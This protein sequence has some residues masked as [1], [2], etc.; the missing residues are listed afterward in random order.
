METYCA[1]VSQSTS[2]RN[3]SPISNLP[4]E[5]L[6]KIFVQASHPKAH[7][8][9][10]L[11]FISPWA[12]PWLH[13]LLVCRYWHDVALHTTTLW[14][15]IQVHK[16]EWLELSLSRS[17][18]AP[19]DVAMYNM[20]VIPS[21]L[22][23]LHNSAHRLRTLIFFRLVDDED[24]ALLQINLFGAVALPILEEI[25]LHQHGQTALPLM[26]MANCQL[27]SLRRLHLESV[28]IPWSSPV[29]NNLRELQLIFF[30]CDTGG[31]AEI[32][33]GDFL[34][35]LGR[36]PGLEVLVLDVTEFIIF[37]DPHLISGLENAT[38]SYPDVY[39]PKM[40]LITTEW[41]TETWYDL[42]PPDSHLLF[43]HLR[44]PLA[45]KIKI[46]AEVYS[47][48]GPA[49][50]GFQDMVPL[51]AVALPILR[52]ATSAQI[53]VET[54]TAQVVTSDGM[55]GELY[56]TLMSGSE[57]PETADSEG[58]WTY[59]SDARLRDASILLTRA[60]L[61]EMSISAVTIGWVRK[62]TFVTAFKV[63]SA[64]LRLLSI[65]CLHFE[66][67]PQLLLALMTSELANSSSSA[68][69][70]A[71]LP[72]LQVLRLN[73]VPWTESMLGMLYDCLCWREERAV[74]LSE[75]R[76][77]AHGRDKDSVDMDILITHASDVAAIA[78][79]VKGSF[80]YID[81]DD[82]PL[83]MA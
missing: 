58:Q 37:R 52:S 56:I 49:N 39:F 2:R 45:A 15:Q 78:T 10:D 40:R 73:N 3:H 20:D 11:W 41:R 4:V 54:V 64:T 12:R 21:V 59:G 23:L 83:L 14:Q 75:L 77:E 46:N 24:A 44:L 19:V 17:R 42:S 62:D 76:I 68:A 61:T 47:D 29:F 28:H 69:H 26:S 79:L 72:H 81:T 30:E 53:S 27:P 67:M 51:D 82:N 71:V 65:E 66:Q 25:A 48:A 8:R 33:F 38:P 34:A 74:A 60:P 22:P 57:D 9:E 31:R 36:I 80:I 16:V 50:P 35:V 63:F 32:A 1:P 7:T 5:I 13:I 55:L 43:S 70:D 18:K 6:S